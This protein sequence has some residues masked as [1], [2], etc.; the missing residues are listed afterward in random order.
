MEKK[1]E[2]K[3]NAKGGIE[4]ELIGFE[5]SGC[6]ETAEKFINALGQ[7]MKSDKKPEYYNTN[8]TRGCQK[9]QGQ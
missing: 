3:V 6:S 1:I 9:N 7:S 8:Q 2:I 4:M 5:G